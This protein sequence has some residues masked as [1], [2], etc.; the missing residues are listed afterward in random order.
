[1]DTAGSSFRDYYMIKWFTLHGQAKSI[2]YFQVNGMKW[3]RNAPESWFRDYSWMLAFWL[4]SHQVHD[5]L[6]SKLTVTW[7]ILEMYLQMYTLASKIN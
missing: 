5:F 1:M 2:Y 7:T 6:I 4:L 3:N